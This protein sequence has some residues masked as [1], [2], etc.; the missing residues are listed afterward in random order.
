MRRL[1]FMGVVL[2]MALSLATSATPIEPPQQPPTPPGQ[3]GETPS[4]GAPLVLADQD[5]DGISDPLQQQIEQAAPGDKFDVVATFTLPQPAAAA[6]AAVGSFAVARQFSII[7]GFA[8]TMTAAQIQALANTPGIFRI[9]EGFEVTANLDGAVADFGAGDAAFDF[10]VDGSGPVG[11]Q[12][13]GICVL[14]TGADPGHEQLDNGK[15][16]AFKDFIKNRKTSYDDHGHGTHV[17]STAAGD[18]IGGGN[19]AQYAGVAPA[20]A[21]YIGKVLDANGSGSDSGVVSGVEWCA[22][23]AGVHII[24]MSLGSAGFTDGLDAMSLAVNCATD[25]DWAPTCGPPAGSPKIAVVAAGNAGPSPVTIGSPGAAAK[26][27]TVG[28]VSNPSGDGMGINLAAFSSRG[29]TSDGRVKPDIAAPGVRIQAAQFRT[30]AGYTTLSGTSMA[31]PFVAGIV[32]LMLDAGPDLA[33]VD[34]ATGQLP[35][36][37]IRDILAATAVDRGPDGP[38][39]PQDNE[40]G[41]GLIDAYAAIAQAS[42]LA[43]GAYQPND[44]PGYQWESGTIATADEEWFSQTFQVEAGG[45][46][47]AATLTTLTGEAICTDLFLC[48]F[49]LGW[50]WDPDFDIELLDADTGAFVPPASDEITRSECPA[51]GEFCGTSRQETIYY[52]PPGPGSYKF[53]VYSNSNGGVTPNGGDFLL[54]VSGVITL[55]ANAG[56][57]QIVTDNDDSGSESVVLDGSASTNSGGVIASYE[58]REGGT[59]LGTG[60]ILVVPLTIGLH[61]ITLTVSDPEGGTDSDVLA[62]TVIANQAP[63]AAAGG[64]MTV[65]DNDDNGQ[66]SFTLDGSASIDPG[67]G[68]IVA[69]EWSEGVVSLGSGQTL[70]LTRGIGGYTF[71]LTVTDQAGLQS[72]DSVNV[73]VVA[74]QA[75]IADAGG[76]MTV[77]DNDGSGSEPVHLDGSASTDPGGTIVAYEWSDATGVVGT[78]ATLDVVLAIGGYSYTLKVTDQVGASS[79]DTITVTVLANQTPVADAGPDQTLYD[80]DGSGA[81]SVTLDGSG[82]AD[83]GGGTIVAYEWTENGNPVGSGPTI[84]VTQAIDAVVYRLTVTDETGASSSDDTTGTAN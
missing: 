70:N 5:G 61:Q 36:D 18:G 25:P 65:T 14:D 64:D 34:G 80:N 60:E 55:T 46:P 73:T 50:V 11:G 35:V 78:Q 24:S 47:L 79:T 10:A 9:E 8:A 31:T 17:A 29:P 48:G 77:T 22:G 51:A 54:E 33:T 56:P 45:T 20:A 53:R 26:P 59:L 1:G 37:R 84:A 68:T 21:L 2:A 71:T 12:P 23:Q 82:S 62:V 81:E 43:P 40:Y 39:G 32:A 15:I 69:Y 66:E 16:V 28:A 7:N 41:H 44:F 4:G 57:D 58:W 83:P 38:A 27:I 63:V 13:V 74:N 72:S 76:D 30:A 52:L 19:A 67:G 3:P 6:Q 49:G 42:G 75:P